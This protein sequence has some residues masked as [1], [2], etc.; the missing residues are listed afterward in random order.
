L[1]PGH[2]VAGPALVEAED[3]TVVIEPGWTLRI[4]EYLDGVIERNRDGR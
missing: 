3:T 2:V 1:R 4:G